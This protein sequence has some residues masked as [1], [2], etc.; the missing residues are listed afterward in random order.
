M[1]ILFP[2]IRYF[3]MLNFY[4]KIFYTFFIVLLFVSIWNLMPNYFELGRFAIDKESLVYIFT[5]LSKLNDIDVGGGNGIN[6]RILIFLKGLLEINWYGLGFES[7]TDISRLNGLPQ[8]NAI[9]IVTILT[10][11]GFIGGGFIIIYM[12]IIINKYKNININIFTFLI[13]VFIL[14]LMS[15]PYAKFYIIFY[16]YYIILFNKT[17]KELQQGQINARR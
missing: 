11:F 1:L 7:M 16:V 6:I 2:L 9:G 17:K 3:F 4:L 15:P 10:D 12:L 14:L 13:G 5:N 8:S